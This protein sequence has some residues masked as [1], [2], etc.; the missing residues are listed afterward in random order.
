MATQSYRE[1][2]KAARAE[3]RW[4]ASE[5]RPETLASSNPNRQCFGG[6][7]GVRPTWKKCRGHGEQKP[8]SVRFSS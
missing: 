3:D 2:Q 6:P 7:G 1:R 5:C 8:N 4:R